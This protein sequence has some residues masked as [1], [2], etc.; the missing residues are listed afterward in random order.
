LQT[1]NNAVIEIYSL[2]GDLINRQ[3]FG[4]GIY[5]VSFGHLPKGLYIARVYF[6]SE[7]LI[8]R[9]PVR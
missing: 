9:V 7:K 4:S 2:S 5:A 1:T 8:L 3:K 6:G